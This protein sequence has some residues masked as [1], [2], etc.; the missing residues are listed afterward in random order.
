MRPRRAGDG[1]RRECPCR[2][3]RPWSV[4]HCIRRR[5]KGNGEAMGRLPEG[6]WTRPARQDS[7]PGATKRRVRPLNVAEPRL[8][9]PAIRKPQKSL[10]VDL[11]ADMLAVRKGKTEVACS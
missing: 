9:S 10:L 1:A 6:E 3:H 5:D 2:D 7:D 4:R 11:Y 8:S